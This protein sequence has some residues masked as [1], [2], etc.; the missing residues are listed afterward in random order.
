[1]LNVMEN[2]A[3]EGLE[4]RK[5]GRRQ[6]GLTSTQAYFLCGR[7]KGK[8]MVRK[9]EGGLTERESGNLKNLWRKATE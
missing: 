7:K 3:G 4:L 8:E 2:S 1:L 6:K 5:T 9:G